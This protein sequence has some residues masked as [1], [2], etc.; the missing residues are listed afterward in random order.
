MNENVILEGKLKGLK[1]IC[2]SLPIIGVIFI[3]IFDLLV[4]LNDYS[5]Y[6]ELDFAYA[7]GS[8]NG[9]NDFL[10][11]MIPILAII[12]Y[13]V[14][15]CW[16]KVSITVTD[17]RV[18]GNSVTGKRVDLPLDSITAVGTS[19]FSG[20]AVTTASGVIKFF[21][22]KNRDQL[23]KVISNL[24]IERQGQGKQ[25]SSQS[26]ADE[27]KKYKELLDMGVIS[28]EEF[29]AKKRQLLGL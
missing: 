3:I 24:L 8:G 17:K 20:L 21:G 18:Y 29:D 11:P 26:Y 22:L 6:G 19:L 14:Y 15:L 12:G 16:S 4:M 2:M 23:Y 27:L 13:I 5:Y 9:A 25:V 7:F 10:Y 1:L 28:Q